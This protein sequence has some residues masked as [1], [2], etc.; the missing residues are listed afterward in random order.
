MSLY[1][2][3][4]CFKVSCHDIWYLQIGLLALHVGDFCSSYQG[5]NSTVSEL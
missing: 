3:K 5:R 1:E 2:R 4:Q